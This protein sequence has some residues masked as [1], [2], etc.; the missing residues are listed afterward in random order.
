MVADAVN[1]NEGL[2]ARLEERLE[3]KLNEL[4]KKLEERLE[5]LQTDWRTES[6]CEV[7]RLRE[8]VSNSLAGQQAAHTSNTQVPAPALTMFVM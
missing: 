7:E 4:E 3:E 1:I 5:K 2:E 6:Q 8:E